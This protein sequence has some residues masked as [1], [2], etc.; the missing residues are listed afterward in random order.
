MGIASSAMGKVGG[1]TSKVLGGSTAAVIGNVVNVGSAAYTFNNSQKQGDNAA[2]SIAKTG[3]DLA[4]GELMSGFGLKGILGYMA[5][6]AGYDM[7]IGTSKV[8]AQ[9]QKQMSG[10]GSGRVGSGYFNMS[11]AGYTMRQRALNQIRNNGQNIQSVLGNEARNYVKAA[12][13]YN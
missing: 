13:T 2:V 9:L 4:F 7:M 12:N 11:G 1:M 6:S 5:V 3:A 8:N 10:T